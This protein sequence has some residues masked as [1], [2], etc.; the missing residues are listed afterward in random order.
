LLCKKTNSFFPCI[1]FEI[2]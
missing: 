1:K 2:F